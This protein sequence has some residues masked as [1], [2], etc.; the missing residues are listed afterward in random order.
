MT[1]TSFS[2][3]KQNDNVFEVTVTDSITTS[4]TVTVTDKDL[5]K[6]TGESITK[7]QL[8]E[9]SFDFLLK[10]NQT[11]LFCPHSNST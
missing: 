1:R 11:H 9:F 7:T 3:E 8:I 4:H 2:V 5:Y 10:K 6:I